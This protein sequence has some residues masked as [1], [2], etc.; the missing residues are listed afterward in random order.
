MV[1]TA[2]RVHNTGRAVWTLNGLAIRAAQSIGL[3]RDGRK[4]GLSPFESE[5]RRRLWWYFLTRDGRAAED[6]GL[7]NTSCLASGADVP[8][9]LEDGDLFPEMAELPPSRAGWTRMTMGLASIQIG[10]AYA[11]LLQLA[12]SSSEEPRCD[13][14]DRIVQGLRCRVDDMLKGCNPV[15]PSHRM[16]LLTARFLLRKLDFVT[17][18]QWQA[19]KH[20]N[21]QELLAMEGSLL[22]ALSILE[23]E[24]HIRAD[25]LLRPFRWSMRSYPQ[26]H[27]TLFI[28]WHVCVRPAGPSARRAFEAVESYVEEM[29]RARKDLL[30]GS[31][32][33]ILRALKAK[34]ATMI[35]PEQG[36]GVGVGAGTPAGADQV[37]NGEALGSATT[38]EF[39]EMSDAGT[40]GDIHC[41]PGWS[42]L[43]QDFL[44]DETNFSVLL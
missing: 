33:T 32:W 28:L 12:W 22:E 25:D 26:F 3:H 29:E 21:E 42:T 5:L 10:Q 7:H 15:I 27:L 36:V 41:V 30:R 37:G 24:E 14:R 6:Y 18:Q 2:L 19:F 17:R 23:E 13:I 31:K 39:A 43:L 11:E 16:S 38:G 20:P 9:N 35:P 4:L 1:Q 34:A 44:Q 8:L 40:F